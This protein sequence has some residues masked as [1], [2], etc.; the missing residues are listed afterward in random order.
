MIKK[1]YLQFIFIAGCIIISG[2]LIV[3]N[4]LAQGEGPIYEGPV[5]RGLGEHETRL[6]DFLKTI[7]NFLYYF[8]M[9]LALIMI[10]ISG[11]MYITAQSDDEKIKKAK[12]TLVSGII[13]TAIVLAAGFIIDAIIS[14]ITNI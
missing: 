9:G 8:A 3:S 1:N 5:T 12:K 10:V 2:F 6:I 11:I 14:V 13:G 4:V 7:E